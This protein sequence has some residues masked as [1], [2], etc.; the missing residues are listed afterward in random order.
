MSRTAGSAS[1]KREGNKEESSNKKKEKGNRRNNNYYDVREKDQVN[2]TETTNHNGN[3][4]KEMVRDLSGIYLKGQSERLKK[5]NVLNQKIIHFRFP[6]GF[7]MLRFF[8]LNPG[9]DADPDPTR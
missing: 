4:D 7:D 1:R 2:K 8:E 9:P 3:N 5:N 6:L